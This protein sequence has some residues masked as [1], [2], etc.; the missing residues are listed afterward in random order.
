MRRR[1]PSS[2]L[3]ALLIAFLLVAAA[4]GD[5]DDDG[6]NAAG[7][8]D[9]TSTES[10]SESPETP[11]GGE[12]GGRRLP[13]GE[14][15]VEDDEGEPVKG[16]TL[17]YGIEADTAN[18]WPHYRASLATAGYVM[19]NSV[20]DPLFT[21]TPDGDI[22]PMLVE[23]Y[24]PNADFTQWTYKIRNGIKFHDGTP[25]DGKAV[26]FNL[27]ACQYSAL[28]GPALMV[29]DSVESSG[30]DVIIKTRTPAVALPRLT[31]ERACAYMF[32]P[33]WLGSL[34]DIPQRK[35]GVAVY[36]AALAATPANGDPTKPVGLGAFTFQSYTPGNG[37][38]FKLVR[39]EDYWR[40]PNGIT[41]EDLPY[42]DAVEGVASVDIDSRG[43]GLRSGQFDIIHSSNADAISQFEDDGDFEVIATSHFGDTDHIMFN[44]AEGDTDPKGAN[45]SSPLLNVHCRRALAAATDVER[46]IEDRAAGLTLQ[47]NG[48][49]GPG[50]LGYLDD[51]GYPTYDPKVA[52]DEMDTCLSELGRDRIE[53]TYNTTNDPFNV[54][55]NT[56]IIS[57]WQETFGDQVAATITPIEQGQYIGLALTG[58][59]QAFAW[60]NF[61]GI[62]PWTQNYWW[63]SASSA[64]IGSLALNF[65]RF[66]DPEIDAAIQVLASNPDEAARQEAAESIN[67]RFGEQV[68][69]LWTTWTLWAVIE[70]PYV[71]GLESNALPDGGEGLGLAFSGRHLMNQ[72]WC[73]DGR[74]E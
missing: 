45:A 58:N 67:R 32:S 71:N 23:S 5:S 2:V 33:T 57:M 50:M 31:T 51:T 64:P 43:N 72:I 13:A 4:C 42:L 44:V 22:A 3:L 18:P 26:E 48:P 47:A 68:Y 60:R 20:T 27:E 12:E 7:T 46:L 34:P 24:T 69:N 30:Q 38:S 36:D 6:G 74:C 10:G 66:K 15:H 54:E 16:G 41:G 11:A 70:A 39:N 61:G 65:G 55:T 19:I 73:D 29:V 63:A 9:S 8:E 62:D 59:F 17:V 14:S 25:L 1:E 40:G 52:Q 49:F 35:Q 53:F 21:A 56:L 28:S 37:N